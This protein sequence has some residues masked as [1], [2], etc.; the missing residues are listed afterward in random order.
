[1]S[2]YLK[3]ITIILLIFILNNCTAQSTFGLVQYSVI[4]GAG[5]KLNKKE[6]IKFGINLTKPESNDSGDTYIDFQ[7][8]YSPFKYIGVQAGHYRFNTIVRNRESS[9]VRLSNLSIGTYCPVDLTKVIDA[10]PY[11]PRIFPDSLLFEFYGGAMLGKTVN[12]DSHENTPEDFHVSNLRMQNYFIRGGWTYHLWRLSFNSNY[13][14]GYLNFYKGVYDYAQG[15]TSVFS[16]FNQ[17][18]ADNDAYYT[19]V[20]HQLSYHGKEIQIHIGLS[21]LNLHEPSNIRFKETIWFGGLTFDIQ[22]ILN[23][24][25]N[26]NTQH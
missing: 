10:L 25:K 22:A 26:Y 18:K 1:M 2:P 6:D 14:W 3:H 9:K 15:S 8:G 5:L 16:R 4:N 19:E 7:M 20:T 13:K 21:N 23:H 24:N 11:Y 17:I 12:K